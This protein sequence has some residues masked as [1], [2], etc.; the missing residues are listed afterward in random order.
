MP[1][2]L[3]L[4]RVATVVSLLGHPLILA[5]VLV[6]FVAYRQGLGAGAGWAIGS[7]VLV[8]VLPISWWNLRQTRRGSYTNFDVSERKQRNSF[9][10]LLLGLL[11]LAT[12]VVFWQQPADGGFRYGLLAAWAL[13]LGCYGL[14]FWL[15][16]SLHAAMSFFLAS[17]LLYMEPIGG[18]VAVMVAALIA[19]SRLVLRRHTL[20]ELLVG[21]LVGAAAGGALVWFLS[22]S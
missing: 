20:L 22:Q 7:V 8:V 4:R 5:P 18:G 11:G 10:P 17:I 19:A 3:L 13:L 1:D 12:L 2:S 6:A 14:N 9:Y 16:V 21:S 15:K